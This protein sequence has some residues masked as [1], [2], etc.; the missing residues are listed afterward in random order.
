MIQTSSNIIIFEFSL[1]RRFHFEKTLEIDLWCSLLPLGGA[2]KLHSCLFSNDRLE[3]K[4]HQND[5]GSRNSIFL[6]NLI[7]VRICSIESV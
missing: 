1:S 5:H 6:V 2:G 7:D 3:K 4:L